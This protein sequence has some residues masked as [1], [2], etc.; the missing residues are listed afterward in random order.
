MLVPAFPD[1]PQSIYDRPRPGFR[2]GAD[3]PRPVDLRP[4]LRPPVPAAQEAVVGSQTPM[5]QRALDGGLWR[6]TWRGLGHSTPAEPGTLSRAKA[7]NPC[8]IRGAGD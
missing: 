4:P 2:V 7:L 3:P 8:Q 1:L 6:E 5:V